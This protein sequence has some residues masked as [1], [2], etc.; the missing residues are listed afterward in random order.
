MSD[1]NHTQYTWKNGRKDVATKVGH[2]CT[3]AL[4]FRI[5]VSEL[6]FKQAELKDRE[7]KHC[8]ISNSEASIE[9]GVA[10][11]GFYLFIVLLANGA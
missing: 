10:L 3:L 7:I 9:R 8:W 1:L 6:T 4:L 11:F 2:T 5:L